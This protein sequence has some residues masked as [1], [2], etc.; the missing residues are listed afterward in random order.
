MHLYLCQEDNF[1][2][3]PPTCT[4]CFSPFFSPVCIFLPYPSCFAFHFTTTHDSIV[5]DLHSH[6]MCKFNIL[7]ALILLNRR[8]IDKWYLHCLVSMPFCHLASL[9]SIRHAL[10]HFTRCSLVTISFQISCNP[11]SGT[12]IGHHTMWIL[13]IPTSLLII[14]G[15]K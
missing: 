10:T 12:A 11:L 7:H 6:S 13:I 9:I 14:S 2:H 5:S 8:E 1:N 15:N 3:F 4:T